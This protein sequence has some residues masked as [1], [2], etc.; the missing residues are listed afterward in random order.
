MSDNEDIFRGVGEFCVAQIRSFRAAT[1]DRSVGGGREEIIV[2]ETLAAG[3]GVEMIVA[4]LAQAINDGRAQRLAD[5]NVN[6]IND[7]NDLRVTAFCDECES[8]GDYF[9]LCAMSRC[10]CFFR[11]LYIFA[12]SSLLGANG[13]FRFGKLVAS[14]EG[15]RSEAGED[16]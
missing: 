6:S 2:R 14:M 16:V 5:G 12:R 3:R 13:H 10:S 11:Y 9:L 8:N 7:A 15:G 1:I 4:Q